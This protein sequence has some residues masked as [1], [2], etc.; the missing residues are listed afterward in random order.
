MLSVDVDSTNV[1][2]LVLLRIS[3]VDDERVLL[4]SILIDVEGVLLASTVIDVDADV[5]KSAGFSIRDVS[6]TGVDVVCAKTFWKKN[7]MKESL[8][9]TKNDVGAESG[10]GVGVGAGTGTGT[11]TSTGA[12][13]TTGGGTITVSVFD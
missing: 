4:A 3:S 1:D 8:S 12:V 6:V 9:G 2:E 5:T 10:A 13:S 7:A 11:G